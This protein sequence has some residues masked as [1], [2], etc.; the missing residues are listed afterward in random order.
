MTE[1]KQKKTEHPL[2]IGEIKVFAKP[3]IITCFGLGSCIGLFLYDRIHKIGGGAHIM[4]PKIMEMNENNGIS[5][6]SYADFAVE[7]LITRM[8][9]KG[10]HTSLR[11]KVVGGANL[12][13]GDHLQVGKN[14]IAAV[15][16]QLLQNRIYMAGMDVGGSVSRTAR[17]YTENGSV[18][19]STPSYKHII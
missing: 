4:L 15:V 14:N 17:F 8:K 11:A 1:T 2:N 10:S 7:S 18:A 12:F 19:V 16:K 3:T 6:S 13:A 9:I 5:M